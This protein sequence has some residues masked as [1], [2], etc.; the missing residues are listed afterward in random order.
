MDNNFGE[1]R[2]GESWPVSLDDTAQLFP[3]STPLASHHRLPSFLARLKGTLI[4]HV[5]IL[6]YTHLPA[7]I[8]RTS[9]SEIKHDQLSDIYIYISL[10]SLMSN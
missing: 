10:S 4:D 8:E 6:P 5:V 1:E 2:E 7:E 9:Y 3:P